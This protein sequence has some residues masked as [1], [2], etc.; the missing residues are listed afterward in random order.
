MRKG[1][2]GSKK[3]DQEAIVVAQG[4]DSDGLEQNEAIKMENCHG[5][6][7]IKMVNF[8]LDF[9]G[10]TNKLANRWNVRREKKMGMIPRFLPEQLH[11]KMC[12]LSHK[13]QVWEIQF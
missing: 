8:W 2:S 13:H 6:V 1:S 12:H 4:R 11:E 10:R 7:T 9:Q 5:K 3:K